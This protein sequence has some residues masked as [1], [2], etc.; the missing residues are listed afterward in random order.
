MKNF[1]TCVAIASTLT[2]MASAQEAV[3]IQ[4]TG[5]PLEITS[6]SAQYVEGG[7]YSTEG[8]RHA[9]TLK[10]VGSQEVLAYTIS[11]RSFDVF[12]EDMGRGLG[13]I[14]IKTLAPGGTT[15]GSWNQKPYAAFSFEKYG[16]GVAYISRVRLGDGTIWSADQKFVLSRLQ[17]IQDDLT[18]DIFEN[19]EE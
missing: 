19:K 5:S 11:F 10:N 3:V 2:S 7:R 1:L 9:V 12:N 8:V 18:A 15:D 4:Q 16:T 17:E 13:G 14:S 6:Y